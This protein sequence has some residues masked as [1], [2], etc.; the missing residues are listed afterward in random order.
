[1]SELQLN[2]TEINFDDLETDIEQEPKTIQKTATKPETVR[3]L[4]QMHQ[5]MTPQKQ[6]SSAELKKEAIEKESPEDRRAR[7]LIIGKYKNSA[8]FGNF[9]QDHGFKLD[10]DTL[11]KLTIPELD[12][13]INDI[14]FTISSKNMGNFYQ[15]AF[16]EGIKMVEIFSKNIM[17]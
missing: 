1:M 11:N 4:P 9:L 15:A 7:L 13:I 17:M 6:K 2:D 12:Y 16:T 14:R 5:K 10:P 3:K 8:R